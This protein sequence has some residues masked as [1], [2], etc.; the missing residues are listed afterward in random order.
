MFQTTNQYSIWL[1]NKWITRVIQAPVS[2]VDLRLL[3]LIFTTHP[4]NKNI[5]VETQFCPPMHIK[6][7]TRNH[8]LVGDFHNSGTLQGM[9]LILWGWN[10]Y[11]K[12]HQIWVGIYWYHR[13]SWDINNT[14]VYIYIYMHMSTYTYVYLYIYMFIYIYICGCTV[15]HLKNSVG[16]KSPEK[17]TVSVSFQQAIG[18][19]KVHGTFHETEVLPRKT[20]DQWEISRI[21]KWRHCTIS[22]HILWWYSLT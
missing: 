6:H 5:Y 15:N 12:I 19:W 14:D 1:A 11:W 20:M 2:K 7:Q 18:W 4:W 8:G 3:P 13:E 9:E 17:K 21:L 16:F 22:G 10:S